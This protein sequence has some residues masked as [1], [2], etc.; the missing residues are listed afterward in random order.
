MDRCREGEIPDVR[1]NGHSARCVLAQ[2]PAS[3]VPA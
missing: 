3:G 2:T 1:A